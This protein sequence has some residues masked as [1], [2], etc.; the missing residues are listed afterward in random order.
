MDNKESC[1]P[2]GFLSSETEIDLTALKSVI[3][4]DRR[5]MIILCLVKSS[6]YTLNSDLLKSLL[7]LVGHHTSSETLHDDHSWLEKHSL[8]KCENS[9]FNLTILTLSRTGWDVAMGRHPLPCVRRPHPGEIENWKLGE[10][11]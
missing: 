7:G 3:Q 2:S 9:E 8:V 6:G 11:R 10:L 1:N 5:L 4:E